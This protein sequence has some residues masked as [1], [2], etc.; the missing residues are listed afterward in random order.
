M[1][2]EGVTIAPTGVALDLTSLY[3]FDIKKHFIFR[4]LQNFYVTSKWLNFVTETF[5][6]IYCMV[7]K[8][9]IEA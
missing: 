8:K 9:T 1:R 4:K 5:K 7:I 2:N 6:L 3:I